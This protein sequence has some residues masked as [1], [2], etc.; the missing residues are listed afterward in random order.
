MSKEFTMIANVGGQLKCM[1]TDDPS[2]Y[3]RVA[4]QKKDYFVL[5]FITRG[6]YRT[7]IH[8]FGVKSFLECS[9]GCSNFEFNCLKF[10][11]DK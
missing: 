6:N 1:V 9:E 3:L 5:R 4:R 11:Y 10:F 8:K 2:E 7:K